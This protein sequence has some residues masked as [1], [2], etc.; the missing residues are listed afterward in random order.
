MGTKTTN[1]ELLKPDDKEFYDI[2]V[3]N[4]NADLIDAFF[5]D[6]KNKI[7]EHKTIYENNAINVGRKPGTTKGKYSGAVGNNAVATGNSAFATGQNTTA[8][9][10]FSHVEGY[11]YK[12]AIDIVNLSTVTNDEVIEIWKGTKFSLA[13][14]QGAHV[15]GANNL[16][17]GSWC[18]IEGSDN[19]AKAD[20]THVEGQGNIAGYRYQHVSGKYNNNKS[21]NLF[22]VGNGTSDENRSNAFEVDKVGNGTFVGNVI[23]GG[24]NLTKLENKYAIC[25]TEGSASE[26]VVVKEGFV[27]E[28]GA[29][30][31]I[32]FANTNTYGGAPTLNVN[33][34]GA[35][36][37][38]AGNRIIGVNDLLANEVYRFVYDGASYKLIG[39]YP[40]ASEV[41][42][43][44]MSA[45]D[46]KK[47]D[48]NTFTVCD[49]AGSFSTKEVVKDGFVLEEGAEI[50]VKFVNTNTA[51]APT[52]NVNGTGAKMMYAGGNYIKANELLAGEVYRFVYD[53]TQYKLI[54]MFRLATESSPGLMSAEDKKKLN[55]V[56]TT[57]SGVYEVNAV[58]TGNLVTI[59]FPTSFSSI[60][61]VCANSNR[62]TVNISIN[63]VTTSTVQLLLSGENLASSKIYWI[64]VI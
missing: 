35:K 19:I 46:K 11:S 64:A 59:N 2:Q 60:P 25:S 37:M 42:A 49:T 12:S 57:Q 32:K 15:E 22:E 48:G 31:I 30:I 3:F 29:E 10:T 56:P 41:R 61:V 36:M 26:K 16:G 52:L 40:L 13:K 58:G 27:L 47:L 9:A 6:L 51:P 50:I 24:K 43:G 4:Y 21:E 54:G 39:T 34:T 44:L 14:S 17:L 38:Y 5:A 55:K 23:S 33:G 28:E 1:M 20:A 62:S 45:K 53:G 7:E 8:S 18:H 63:S